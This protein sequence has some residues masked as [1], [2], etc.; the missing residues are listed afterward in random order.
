V[1]KPALNLCNIPS[2]L[3]WAFSMWT[4]QLPLGSPTC[5]KKKHLTYMGTGFLRPDVIR[6]NQATL[7]K[8]STKLKADSSVK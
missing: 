5:S 7:S 6:V 4:S 8:H 3:Q 1:E 2:P